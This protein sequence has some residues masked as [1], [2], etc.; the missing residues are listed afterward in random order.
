MHP[1]QAALWQTICAAPHDDA[2]RLIYADWLEEHDHT[3]QAEFIRRQI[4]LSR[5]LELGL[6]KAPYTR[7]D[8]ERIAELEY[9]F[10]NRWWRPLHIFLNKAPFRRGFCSPLYDS[11]H[12]RSFPQLARYYQMV[13]P[14]WNLI[15]ES[16]ANRLLQYA[17]QE[18]FRM[19]VSL[20]L[21][22]DIPNPAS[23]RPFLNAFNL[24][25][26]EHLI[27]DIDRIC[28]G[29]LEVMVDS[30]LPGQ[31]RSFAICRESSISFSQLRA[32]MQRAKFPT[33]TQLRLERQQLVTDTL[34]MLHQLIPLG[35][36]TELYLRDNYLDGHAL[37]HI[38][39]YGHH[40]HHLDMSDNEIIDRDIQMLADWPNLRNL[41]WLKISH[42]SLSEAACLQLLSSPNLNPRTKV[43][44]DSEEYRISA[45][46]T[47][48][49]NEHNTKADLLR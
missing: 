34:V 3:E 47:H 17:N 14:E 22:S 15:M 44:I 43:I 38:L 26:V 30:P 24:L 46:I 37:Q 25:N 31:L 10:R 32:A 19:V 33:L 28:T 23:L 18:C 7:I 27:L 9:E 5:H 8:Q 6:L 2:P 45:V 13:I 20:H 42:N 21:I 12:F 1:E 36:L 29:H 49:T 39:R 35:Q 16:G 41:R 11:R 4:T 48:L 40:L